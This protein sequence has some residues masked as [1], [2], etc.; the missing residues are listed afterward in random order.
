M[1]PVFSQTPEAPEQV[2]IMKEFALVDEDRVR[3]QLSY[4]DIHKSVGP[5]ILQPWV[6]KERA[7]V[8]A[9]PHSCI[10]CCG[11]QET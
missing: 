11:E 5:D 4:L 6:V 1:G 3:D 8:I 10:R 9:R 2:T 7:E